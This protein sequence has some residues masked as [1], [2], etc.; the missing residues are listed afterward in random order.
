MSDFKQRLTQE[1]VELHDKIV[2]LERFLASGTKVVGDEYMALQVQQLTTM[3]QYENI[4]LRRQEML[5]G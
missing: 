1:I 3:K 4:L 5:N 2:K